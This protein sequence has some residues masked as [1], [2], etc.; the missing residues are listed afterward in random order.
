MPPRLLYLLLFLSLL[1]YLLTGLFLEREDFNLL[2]SLYSSLFILYFLLLRFQD[3]LSLRAGIAAG[4]LFRV[5]LLF[6]FPVLS[7]DVYRFLWDG[8]LQQ[9]G[10]NPFDYT[11][12][13]IIGSTTDSYLQ[14]LFPL[15]NSPDYYSV[16]PQLLQYIFRLAA[17]FS[18][19]SMLA[20]II[21]LKSVIFIFECLTIYLTITLLKI[22]NINPRAVFIY[23]FNPLIVIELTG[24]IHFEALMIFFILLTAW[25]L[26][27][28][29]FIFAALPLSMA[30]Q[31]KLIPLI[32]IPLLINKFGYWK[33]GIFGFTCCLVLF[34]S[35]PVLWGGTE[36][37]MNLFSSLQLYYGK[38]EFNGSIYSV[39]RAAG[40]SILG[41]NPI[42]W[43]SKI[44]ILLTLI[45]FWFIYRRKLDFLQ[46]FFW[47]MV[48]YLLFS[49]VVHP[50]YLAILVALSSF[51]RYKFALLWTAF[52]PLTYITYTHT[53]Y[54]QNYWLISLE[55]FL[56]MALAAFELRKNAGQPSTVSLA[57]T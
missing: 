39:L 17:E 9:L 33:T 40:W 43:L 20:G 30:I 42:E 5:S 28:K 8:R 45:T 22:R 24:N 56:V 34:L 51:V 6:S 32:G 13:Q 41:Y 27:K 47:L 44:M 25:L 26:T 18:S 49:A 48:S 50:W 1:A 14:Q 53:P 54:E 57:T 31:A 55:Y 7:D 21:V 12:K 35:S 46:G 11:P 23:L 3:G 36:R 4:L 2:I 10:I 52:I 16:Y 19:E 38:F 29:P 15:L 37:I